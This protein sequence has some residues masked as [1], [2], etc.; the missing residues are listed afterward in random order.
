MKKIEICV[1][2]PP[3]QSVGAHKQ[4]ETEPMYTFEPTSTQALPTTLHPN[5]SPSPP[6]H[7]PR[8]P[9]PQPPETVIL[10]NGAC[11]PLPRASS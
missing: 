3:L 6:M 1:Q 9:F 11:G 5:N 8:H 7:A 10:R 4:P 2:C